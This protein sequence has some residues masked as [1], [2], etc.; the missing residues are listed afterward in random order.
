MQDGSDYK[1]VTD[2]KI[3]LPPY[4][5]VCSNPIRCLRVIITLLYPTA[6]KMTFDRIVPI[7]TT[8]EAEHIAAFTHDWP[9]IWILNLNGVVTVWIWA[10]A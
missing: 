5:G 9:G 4:L 1:G 7:F 6:Q 8:V 10:P 2:A 3:K